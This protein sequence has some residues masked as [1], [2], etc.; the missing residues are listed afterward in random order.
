MFL[1][2]QPNT[3]NRPNFFSSQRREYTVDFCRF[4]C[5]GPR[6]QNRRSAEYSNRYGIA[7]VQRKTDIMNLGGRLANQYLVAAVLCNKSD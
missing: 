1:V 6:I 2:I 7:F 3:S 5:C 4:A